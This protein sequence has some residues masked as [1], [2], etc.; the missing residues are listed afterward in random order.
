[1]SYRTLLVA[2]DGG[3]RT[4]A[5][6]ALAAHLAST[7]E[8]HL[9]GVAATGLPDVVVSINS[10]V[11]DSVECIRLSADL[12][13]RRAEAAADAFS[14]QA[15]AAGVASHEARVVEAEPLDAVVRLAVGADLVVVGQTDPRAR[16]DGVAADFPQQVILHAGVPVL[17]VPYA[18]SYAAIGPRV[19][20]AWK[21][22]RECARALRDALPM[23]RRATAVVLVEIGEP[24]ADGA[25][26]AEAREA[27]VAFLS[28]HGIA[29]ETRFEPRSVGAADALLSLASDLSADLL[30]MGAYGHSRM[31]EWVLGG[32]TREIL[33]RMTLP[34]LMAH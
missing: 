6:V 10:N 20:V 22:T 28:R 32:A 4:V 27:T 12:L 26:D 16:V 17:V 3:P 29:A 34:V 21:D 30:V 14:R 1:M 7:F 11:P 23:L 33:A 19:L 9:V 25:A 8:G 13:R 18:G 2:L 15:Q 5:R 31:T 24:G